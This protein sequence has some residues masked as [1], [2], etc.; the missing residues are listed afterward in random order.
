MSLRALLV[1]SR[2]FARRSGEA[3]L[4]ELTPMPQFRRMLSRERARSDRTGQG[5]SLVIFA[6]RDPRS[7]DGTLRRL[8]IVL[9]RRLR[10]SDEA[11][12]VDGE[13]LGAFL[14]C[15]P[16][17]GAWKVADDVC[18]AFPI[19]LDP[20]FCRVYCYPGV[21]RGSGTPLPVH[22]AA[23]AAGDDDRPVESAEVL[24]CR[25]LPWWKRSLDVLLSA[26]ALV[27]LSP[28]LAVIALAVKLTSPGPV[29]FKQLRSGLGDRP[30][31]MLK[32]RSMT[33]DAERH[34][35][36]LAAL[37]EQDG[38]AFKI[39]ND[40]RVT[41]LGWLLR[42]TSLDE[43][44]Q[45]WNVLRGEMSLVGPRPLPCHETR[46]CAP[47]HR[48]RLQVTPGLTC[49]WQVYGRSRVG[50]DEWMRMDIRY[51]RSQSLWADVKLLLKTIPAVL[52]CKGAQ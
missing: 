27:L 37:N 35:E 33:R 45:L 16:A 23:L 10:T 14:P 36:E 26:V 8:A 50:F 42:R 47:W 5:F 25:G 49:I 9:Q 44:P 38:P 30:F 29:F 1:G 7:V 48:Q 12:W 40:P 43:L 21:N 41:P 22:D 28:L 24:F 3:A 6:P 4:R 51:T 13:R 2:R 17:A 34:R 20:P 15:T 11:G 18:A 39:R 31:M 52:S 19:E 32:F 46:Q